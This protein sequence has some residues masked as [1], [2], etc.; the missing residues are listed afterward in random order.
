MKFNLVEFKKD[1]SNKEMEH[2][3]NVSCGDAH[4]IAISQKGV[5]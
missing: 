5:V 2:I 1:E 4:C 3:L